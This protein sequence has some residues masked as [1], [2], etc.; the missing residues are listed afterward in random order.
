MIKQEALNAI[1]LS[2]RRRRYFF[3]KLGLVLQWTTTSSTLVACYIDEDPCPI[4]HVLTPSWFN[5]SHSMSSKITS[6]PG[7][8]VMHGP[9]LN[10]TPM[11]SEA[12]KK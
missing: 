12:R 5:G 10:H 1:G 9:G 2:Q 4:H 3:D 8:S 6:I 11:A 7:G